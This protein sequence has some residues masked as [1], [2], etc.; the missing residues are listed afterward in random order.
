MRPPS[1]T[2]NDGWKPTV[3]MEKVSRWLEEQDDWR[4]RNDVEKAKLGTAEY[5]RQAMDELVDLNYAAEK[6]G[7]RNARLI[8]SLKP[9]RES[10]FVTSSD[11]VGTSSD[12]VGLTSSTSSSAYRRDEDEDEVE[13][14][15]ALANDYF[16]AQ[17]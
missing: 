5:V 13:R 14:L 8:Q 17:P 11:L 9:F 2:T 3:L 15:A 7:A 10:D 12:E 6:S 1:A 4:S 16:K